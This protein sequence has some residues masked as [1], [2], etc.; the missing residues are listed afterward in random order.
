MEID[1][2]VK[3]QKTTINSSTRIDGDIKA[4]EHLVINGTIKGNVDIRAHNLFLGPGG[5]IEGEIHAHDVR[6]RGHMTG[7]IV[8]SGKVE[9]MKEANFSGKIKSKGISVEQGAYFDAS[10]KL[11]RESSE[12]KAQK[13]LPTGKTATVLK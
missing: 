13:E 7:D 5:K 10:V 4:E 9:I 12:K 8:A 3:E 1:G 11:G 2:V 6:I